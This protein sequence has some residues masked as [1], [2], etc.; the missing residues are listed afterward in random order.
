MSAAIDVF[1]SAYDQDIFSRLETDN[2]P[3]TSWPALK[4]AQART[5]HSVTRFQTD[6]GPGAV[7]FGSKWQAPCHW[8]AAAPAGPNHGL[9]APP[10][11]SNDT[12]RSPRP[13]HPSASMEE[14][15]VGSR[16]RARMAPFDRGGACAQEPAQDGAVHG[17]S[18]RLSTEART[19][20]TSVADSRARHLSQTAPTTA[21]HAQHLP[22]VRTLAG[23][24]CQAATICA[25]GPDG[26]TSATGAPQRACPQRI[27]RISVGGLTMMLWTRSPLSVA[28]PSAPSEARSS[29][30]VSM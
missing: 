16:P 15:V 5:R 27:V 6:F 20:R 8:P 21:H 13:C 29:A 1:F 4:V 19:R 2:E 28:A 30:R 25:H 17:E 10:A 26:A 3:S 23:P 18:T 22:A 7:P 11:P 14:S 9:A 12:G 24:P